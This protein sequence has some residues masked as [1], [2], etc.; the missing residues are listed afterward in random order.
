MRTILNFGAPL[1]IDG[2]RYKNYND[3]WSEQFDI[4]KQFQLKIDEMATEL[5]YNNDEAI[6][7]PT[8]YSSEVR[9]EEFRR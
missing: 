8:F 9:N 6:I 1:D 3:R 2:E 4:I 5:T 7:K